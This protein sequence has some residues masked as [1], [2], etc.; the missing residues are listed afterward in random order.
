MTTIERQLK[1][2][3]LAGKPISGAGVCLSIL[4]VLTPFAMQAADGPAVLEKPDSIQARFFNK[5][6]IEMS[7]GGLEQTGVVPSTAP[8]SFSSIKLAMAAASKPPVVPE[9]LSASTTRPAPSVSSGELT[10]SVSSALSFNAPW[11]EAMRRARSLEAEVVQAPAPATPTTELNSS[12]EQ[13]AS[14]RLEVPERN[15]TGFDLRLSRLWTAF[16][17]GEPFFSF[18]QPG[19]K[20]DRTRLTCERKD[21]LEVHGMIGR[22]G[23]QCRF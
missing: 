19:E 10:N 3:D 17:D 11:V 15:A 8:F 5:S 20:L 16:A 9:D 18:D 4:V 13:S 22:L 2:L 1:A 21:Y 14:A 6:G 23:F 7:G 12:H